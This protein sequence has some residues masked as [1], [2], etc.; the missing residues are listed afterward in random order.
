MCIAKPFGQLD[1]TMLSSCCC[2]GTAC[3]DSGAT[4]VATAVLLQCAGGDAI[5]IA[6]SN[7]GID[8]LKYGHGSLANS[9]CFPVAGTLLVLAM[10]ASTCTGGVVSRLS[11]AHS[12]FAAC[13][14]LSET[15][16]MSFKNVQML[17]GEG[18]DEG[19]MISSGIESGISRLLCCPTKVWQ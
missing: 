12:F 7:P 1:C 18:A 13:T 4:T 9:L 11:F 15:V 8:M 6:A 17:L 2:C 5:A 10:G 3:S 14:R 16:L 19:I